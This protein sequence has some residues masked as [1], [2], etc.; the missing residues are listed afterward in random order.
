MQITRAPGSTGGTNVTSPAAAVSPSGSR[1]RKPGASAQ[2]RS[3]GA[4]TATSLPSADNDATSTGPPLRRM[5][6]ILIGHLSWYGRY[7]PF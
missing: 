1:D 5:P 7:E 2:N 4:S 3:S 6:T